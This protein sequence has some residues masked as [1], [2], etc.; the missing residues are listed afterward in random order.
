MSVTLYLPTFVDYQISQSPRDFLLGY[1]ESPIYLHDKIVAAH[2]SSYPFE[3]QGK[4]AD[5]NLLYARFRRAIE[6]NS[7]EQVI[8]E[9][10]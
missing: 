6:E 2:C 9:P 1:P 4:G 10:R 3:P 7:F 8:I 5:L